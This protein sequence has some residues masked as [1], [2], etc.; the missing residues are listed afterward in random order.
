MSGYLFFQD[1]SSEEVNQLLKILESAGHSYH[2][3]GDWGNDRWADYKEPAYDKQ[4]EDQAKVIADVI[5]AKDAEIEMLRD[6]IYKFVE[7]IEGNAP[8]LWQEGLWSAFN[9]GDKK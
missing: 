2:H 4:I 8:A 6:K 7:W 5:A 1:T 9:E 3:T